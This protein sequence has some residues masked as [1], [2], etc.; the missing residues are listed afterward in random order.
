MSLINKGPSIRTFTTDNDLVDYVNLLSGNSFTTV[1]QALAW[2]NTASNVYIQN[3]DAPPI[4]TEDLVLY[5]DAG[6]VSSM[7]KGGTTWYDLSNTQAHGTLVNGPT[8]STAGEGSV[9]YDSSDDYVTCPDVPINI[10]AGEG[11]TVE[12]WINWNGGTV[13]M[14]FSFGGSRLDIYFSSGNMGFN[15]GN[16]LLYGIPFSNYANEWTHIAAFFPSNWG[17]STYEN[18]KLWVNGIRQDISI[19]NGSIDNIS[20]STPIDIIVGSGFGGNPAQYSFG[21]NIASTKVYARELT[22]EEVLNNYIAQVNRY[23][24]WILASGSWVDGNVWVDSETW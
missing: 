5:V 8:Y 6:Q 12:Q 19:L 2:A 20:L 24:E 21:G 23:Y 3:R 15:N 17:E 4:L 18:A 14:S 13:Q 16:A 9:F 1:Q 7:P 11:N 22:N 10:T